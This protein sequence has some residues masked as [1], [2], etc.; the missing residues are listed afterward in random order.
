MVKNNIYITF[1]LTD[2]NMRKTFFCDFLKN[3]NTIDTKNR[4]FKE[5]IQAT[6][7]K[8]QYLRSS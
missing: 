6:Y 2:K 5:C 1:I 8:F 7:Q 3:L 4:D